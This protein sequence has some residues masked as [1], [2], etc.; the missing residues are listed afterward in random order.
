MEDDSSISDYFFAKKYKISHNTAA[1]IRVELA[2]KKYKEKETE[3][4]ELERKEEKENIDNDALDKMG[5]Q[6]EYRAE[7]APTRATIEQEKIKRHS[8]RLT[9][10]LQKKLD[11]D[12]GDAVRGKQEREREE[13]QEIIDEYYRDE[14]Q[15]RFDNV[16]PYT[17]GTLFTREMVKEILA[18]YQQDAADL[19][20]TIEQMK[21]EQAAELKAAEQEHLG[22]IQEE[23]QE[24]NFAIQAAYNQAK[25]DWGYTFCGSCGQPI[26]TEILAGTRILCPNCLQAE[27][28][29]QIQKANMDT[30]MMIMIQKQKLNRH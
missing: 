10:E 28:T 20:G 1:K 7:V 24:K 30:A 17:K 26:S 8:A 9:E 15:P 3:E 22:K 14:I 21:I 12:E 23:R 11:E 18:P 19:N 5:T 29:F 2:E 6:M 27:Q 4:K 25:Q 16:Y 13:K